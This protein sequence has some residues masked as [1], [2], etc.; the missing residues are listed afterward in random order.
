MIPKGQALIPKLSQHQTNGNSNL[1]LLSAPRLP[2]WLDGPLPQGFPWGSN[3]AQ[4]T[5]P[6]TSPPNTGVTRYY[7]FHVSR[8]IVNPDGAYN[9]SGILINNAFPGPTISAN[10]GDW[11]QVEVF[12]DLTDEGT[13]LHWHGLLQQDTPWFDGVPA[14]QQCPIAPQSSFTYR[15]RADLYGTSWYHSHYSAQYAAGAYGA[16]I[17]YGPNGTAQYDEDMGPILLSDWF[18]TPDYFDLVQTVMAPA[19]ENLFPP[20]S[21]NNL[22]NGKMNYPCANSTNPNCTPN[23]GISKFN[24]TTGKTYRLRLINSGAEGL[25]KFSIDGAKLTIIANDFVPIQPYQ[26]DVVTLA[27]GQRSDVLFTATGKSGD[28]VWMRSTLGTNF[29]SLNDGI[30]PVAMAAI[31]YQNA[32]MTAVPTSRSTVSDAALAYCENDDLSLTT[33][34]YQLTPPS[35]P[36]T[37]QVINITY[38]SNGTHNLFWM[39]NST[40]RANYNDPVLLDAK[41]GHTKFPSEYNVYNFGQS[42]S[43]RL[44]LY[45]WAP[46]GAHPMHLHGHNMY[47]LASGTGIWDGQITN[48][49]NPQRRDV[50]LLPGM[51]SATEPSYTV[52]QI[53]MDSPGVWPF[54]CHIA[55]HVSSG[56]YI[57]ILER[58]RDIQNDVSIPSIMAQTCR[59]WSAWTGDHIPDEIDSGL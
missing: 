58:P 49:N 8:Q 30:S 4:N 15:F 11:I 55:W 48:R 16:M 56:L 14:V 3:T 42:R 59:D 35:H 6:Y 2:P 7:T 10:W 46:A 23:A 5:N 18:H 57:N 32:N 50:M 37:S 54:H 51:P 52:I 17:I 33:P 20:V 53:D 28:A 43:V 40:F 31:Y 38:Q 24:V 41:L 19:A 21:N 12:N 13:S 29:C 1:G 36:D 26:V 27:V 25:Q 44:V 45:N 47:V 9:V 34:L 39:N 22:I